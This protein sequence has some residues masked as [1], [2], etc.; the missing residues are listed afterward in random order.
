M[1]LIGKD[2]QADSLRME[3]LER[4]HHAVVRL[5]PVRGVRGIVAVVYGAQMGKLLLGE[6]SLDAREHPAHLR[7]R[8]IPH[9]LA[10]VL[11]GDG[12][13]TACLERAV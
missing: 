3:L 5:N 10:E 12:W 9:D 11:R 2:R 8:P 6:G 7:I 13:I 1:G 4:V